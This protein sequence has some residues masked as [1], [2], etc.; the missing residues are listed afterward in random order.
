MPAASASRVYLDYAATAPFD[1]RLRSVLLDASWA[2]ANALYEEGREAAAQLRDA[3]ARIARAL[4]AHAPSEIIFTSGGSEGDNMAIKGL[5]KPVTGAA[6]THVV[7]SSIEHH[8]V[9]NAADAL[10]AHGFKVDKLMPGPDGVIT[11]ATLE[12]RLA[13]IEDAGDACC[14]VCVQAVNNELGTIQP[15]TQLAN[16]AHE[17][18][19]LFVCDAV[20][21]LGKIDLDLEASGVDACAFSAH[22]IGAPK[23]IGALY[24]R[25]GTRIA[26]LICGGGQEAGMRSGTSNVPGACAF[27]QAV[28]YAVAEREETWAHA[29][30]LRTRLLDSIAHGSYAHG[31]SV[32]IANDENV[33]PHI[34]S[35]YARGLEGETAVLR[36]DNVGIAISSGSA[37][38]TSSLDPSHVLT[39]IGL[40]RDDALGGIR[41]SFGKD[42]SI[43]D[44]DRFIEILPEVLR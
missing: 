37:C 19:A 33:V 3:R 35:L 17:H 22:K 13:A 34:L 7:V 6:H 39:A 44:I 36:C 18:K 9:L 11:S 23:G 29:F 2:N 8:A 14:L 21:A 42:T 16:I 4:G 41:L 20:Q 38:S 1:E 40:C 24:L 28:E 15:I 30:A 31:L 12:Q 5:A 10:K 25:R 32:T 27:A 26:P 43:E